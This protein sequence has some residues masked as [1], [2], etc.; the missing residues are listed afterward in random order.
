[1]VPE[2]HVE[3]KGLTLNGH[4]VPVVTKKMVIADPLSLSMTINVR[5][6]DFGMEVDLVS[7]GPSGDMSWLCKSLTVPEDIYYSGACRWWAYYSVRLP[8]LTEIRESIKNLHAWKRQYQ[9]LKD[10]VI[11]LLIRGQI[12][13]VDNNSAVVTLGFTKVPSDPG[14][15]LDILSWFC[16]ELQ[17][18]IDANAAPHATMTLKSHYDPEEHGEIVQTI[19]NRLVAHPQALQVLFD[20]ARMAFQIYK[21]SLHGIGARGKA[22]QIP[23]LGINF[24]MCLS[25]GLK[26]L[27]APED[28]CAP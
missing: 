4:T 16:S 27:D 8:L 25:M 12:L 11:L 18:D 9:D 13:Y 21:K 1:M 26:Y 22:L 28:A 6:P 2:F 10:H 3:N 5:L 15:H 23:V 7:F 24:Q 17:K 20:P 14:P 19:I